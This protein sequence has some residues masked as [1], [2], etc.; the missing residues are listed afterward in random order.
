MCRRKHRPRPRRSRS[1]AACCPKP[2]A[3]CGFRF[4]DLLDNDHPNYV[5]DVG[6]GINPKLAARVREADVIIAIGPR[7][8][9]M[10]TS[11]YALLQSPVPKQRLI[12]VH[13]DA[14]ELGSVYQS[15]L[16]IN[17]GMPQ[18]AFMLAAM[19]PVDA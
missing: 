15:E 6:I 10:T 3:P 1:C 11:G 5:G 19:E 9:E 16:M 12:H 4:Q 2:S 17:S 14:E 13:A 7:L 8:G 18:V